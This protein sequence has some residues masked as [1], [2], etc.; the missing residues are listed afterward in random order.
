MIENPFLLYG[1]EGPEYFCDREEETHR[2]VESMSNGTN[3]A[4]IS[5]RRLGKSGLIRHTFH[6]LAEHNSDF[7]CF[8]I[9]L[10]PTRSLSD[11]VNLLGKAIIGQL[12]TPIQKAE[13]FVTRFFRSTQLTFGVDP[14][15]N[16]P[17]VSLS[18][19]PQNSQQTLEE[20]FAYMAQSKVDCYIA[21]DEF[22]QVG[23]YLEDNIE[24]L[25]RSLLER[26]HNVHIIFSGS[27]LHVMDVMFSSPKHPFYR[28]TERMQLGALDED[29]YYTF[30]QYHL[31]QKNICL[32]RDIFHHIY[33]M[34]DGVTWYIQ[35]VLHRLYR[36]ADIEVTEA[37]VQQAVVDIIRSEEED[38]KR[39][40]HHLTQ[41]QAVLL[42]A[43]AVEGAV[44]QPTSGLFVKKYH[45]RSASSVQ[46]A[47]ASL[48]EEEYLY[49]TERGY[50]VYDRFLAIWLRHLE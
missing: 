40:Y 2:L 42:R 37:V 28:S 10:Y 48:V 35:A 23:E 3:V 46:R 8:Y 36:L 29:K 41:V 26:I 9:D 22:Q 6:Y 25:L 18:Y 19:A 31:Q 5:P 11:F 47:L 14:F 17:Q 44:T 38:Y 13:G 45:L 32:S 15:T 1:Y 49:P 4:L 21:L 30:A 50:I 16:L 27:K 43:V 7:R 20:I 24:A 12:D 33:A 39:Q 34:V